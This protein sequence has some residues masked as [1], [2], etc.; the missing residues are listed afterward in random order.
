MLNILNR[1]QVKKC[2][3]QWT[4]L[5]DFSKTTS[6]FRLFFL[7]RSGHN[8]DFAC[9]LSTCFD[10]LII[11]GTNYEKNFFLLMGWPHWGRKNP[12]NG[13]CPETHRLIYF[14]IRYWINLIDI[15][16]L[17][18]KFKK[19]LRKFWNTRTKVK[20]YRSAAAWL[21]F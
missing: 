6:S 11:Q 14:F 2:K 7:Y 21:K 12:K 20:W 10:S 1:Q 18:K 15:V 16:E 8:L 13:H 19:I 5:E 3:W 4:S 9:L 17:K